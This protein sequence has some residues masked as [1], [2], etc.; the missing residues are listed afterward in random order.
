MIYEKFI[1]MK[2]TEI[3]HGNKFCKKNGEK[4]GSEKACHSAVV[5]TAVGGGLW[6]RASQTIYASFQNRGEPRF[7]KPRFEAVLKTSLM[8]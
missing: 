4:P 7:G 2:R 5:K 3:F 6:N 1:E 8:I